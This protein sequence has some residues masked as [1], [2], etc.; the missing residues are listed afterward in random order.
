M[1]SR[2]TAGFHEPVSNRFAD[3]AQPIKINDSKNNSVSLIRTCVI[4]SAVCVN[5]FFANI[6]CVVLKNLDLI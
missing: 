3:E 4:E 6:I 5:Y 1:L 2:S